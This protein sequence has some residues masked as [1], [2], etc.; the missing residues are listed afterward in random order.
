MAAVQVLDRTVA[1]FP[2]GSMVLK[3]ALTNL[4]SACEI[5]KCD[6]ALMS[7]TIQKRK[8]PHRPAEEVT[9]RKVQFEA[10]IKPLLQWF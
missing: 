10:T 8:Q 4:P 2:S 5:G 7:R 6:R 1:I 3:A 9:F